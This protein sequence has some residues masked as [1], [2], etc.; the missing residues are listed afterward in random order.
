[1][2][3]SYGEKPQSRNIKIQAKDDQVTRGDGQSR[4]AGEMEADNNLR[5]KWKQ[6]KNLE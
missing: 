5:K 1:M 3:N 4:V 2:N 6:K